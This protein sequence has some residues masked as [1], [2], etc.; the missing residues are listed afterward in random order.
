MKQTAEIDNVVVGSGRRPRGTARRQFE[1]FR[2]SGGI[3]R[4]AAA[5]L[6]VAS[7]AAAAEIEDKTLNKGSDAGKMAFEPTLVKIEPRRH[8][9]I[10]CRRQVTQCRKQTTG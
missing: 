1:M 2:F 4:D 6:T 9:Q 7:F 10:C 5:I 3:R 8:H